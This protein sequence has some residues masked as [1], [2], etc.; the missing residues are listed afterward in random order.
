MPAEPPDHALRRSRGDLTT[1][2]HALA[3]PTC[4]PVLALLYL[5]G[6]LALASTQLGR[7]RQLRLLLSRPNPRSALART[8]W[9]SLVLAGVMLVQALSTLV[10]FPLDEILVLPTLAL[11]VAL[12]V[13]G[14]LMLRKTKGSKGAR[15]VRRPKVQASQDRRAVFQPVQAGA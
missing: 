14:V 4:T 11:G 7:P 12:P 1:K 13:D 9:Y 5:A 3:D 8:A 2:L 6:S 15:R 10:R